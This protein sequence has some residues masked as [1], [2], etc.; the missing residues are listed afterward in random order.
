MKQTHSFGIFE[1]IKS[2]QDKE[3]WKMFGSNK[4]TDKQT[5]IQ[6]RKTQDTMVS[7]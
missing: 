2:I 1:D 7:F 6:D 5:V 4:S 3:T